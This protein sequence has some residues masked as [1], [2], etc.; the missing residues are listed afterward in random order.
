VF[1]P[2]EMF[3][4][5]VNVVIPMERIHPIHTEAPVNLPQRPDDTTV[6]TKLTA[7]IEI[8]LLLALRRIKLDRM[9]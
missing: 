1:E 9:Q 4:H 3:A 6:G 2:D 5:L 8:E 7:V